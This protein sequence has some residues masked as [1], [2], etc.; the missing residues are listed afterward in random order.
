MAAAPWLCAPSAEAGAE[1]DTV[2]PYQIRDRR[3]ELL[4]DEPRMRCVTHGAAQDKSMHVGAVGVGRE[5]DQATAQG[6]N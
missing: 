1:S 5:S 3:W 6:A 4:W 2:Q